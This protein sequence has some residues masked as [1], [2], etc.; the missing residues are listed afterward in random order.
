MLGIRHFAVLNNSYTLIHLLVWII[1][2]MIVSYIIIGMDPK[3][4]YNT[5]MITAM[6]NKYQSKEKIFISWKLCILSYFDILKVKRSLKLVFRWN[7]NSKRH[8]CCCQFCFHIDAT[9]Q[10]VFCNIIIS[11]DGYSHFSSSFDVAIQVLSL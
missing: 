5:I 4:Q 2:K 8:G 11:S 7:T 10:T 9:Y 6:V 3:E 1:T